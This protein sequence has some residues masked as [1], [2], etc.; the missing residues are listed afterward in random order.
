VGQAVA[1]RNSCRARVKRRI[2]TW[3][4]RTIPPR[5]PRQ[6]EV[7]WQTESRLELE[8]DE[9][10]DTFRAF[11]PVTVPDSRL[12]SPLA[13]HEAALDV[14]ANNLVA[15]STTTGNQYIYD[16]RELFGRFRETTDGSLAYS[17][18]SVR[19]ATVPN[20]FDGCTDSG[21]NAVTTHRTRWCA[22]SLNGCTMRVW[23]RYTW[24]T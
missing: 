15:C 11:Q 18:S 9:V 8:Y 12:D 10:S 20:G 23:R 21:R 16:G 1:S 24:A 13:S 3:L 5:S 22:T 14:G 17:R 6:P 2:R 4:P 19:D 7:G